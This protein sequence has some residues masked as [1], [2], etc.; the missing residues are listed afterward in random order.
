MTVG[1]ADDVGLGVD[2]WSGRLWCRVRRV[3]CLRTVY[4]VHPDSQ[5]REGVTEFTR[6]RICGGCLRTATA[7]SEEM[8]RPFDAI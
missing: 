1:A 4:T 8:D 5:W 7:L 2:A 6:R 3:R